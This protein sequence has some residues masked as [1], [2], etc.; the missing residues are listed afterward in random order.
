M[1]WHIPS[2]QEKEFAREVL[3]TFLLPQLQ[4]V[5]DYVKVEDDTATDTDTDMTPT[6]TRW[7]EG[8]A[9]GIIGGAMGRGR[10][11]GDYGRGYGQREELCAM[12]VGLWAEGGAM[13]NVGG[14][15]GRGRSY[16]QCGWGYGQREELC[17]MWVG[18]W[19]EGGAMC[20][21][22]GAVGEEEAMGNMDG[23]QGKMSGIFDKG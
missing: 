9:V 19:A 13:C 4:K 18:L 22:G 20:N 7:V 16:V 8:G 5:N 15:M 12:W 3:R 23:T 14:A 1:K 11:C 2:S 21:V 6:M 10:S 17:A